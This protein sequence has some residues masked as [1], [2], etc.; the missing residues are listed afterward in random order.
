[1]NKV[2]NIC[3]KEFV[4][5]QKSRI[6]C[7]S[8]SC[9]KIYQSTYMKKYNLETKKEQKQRN[10]NYYLQNKE[11]IKEQ[12]KEYYLKN[13]NKIKK[14]KKEYK[15]QYSLKNKEKI[16]EDSKVYNLKNKIKIRENSR[17]HYLK[18]VEKNTCFCGNKKLKDSKSCVMCCRY[19]LEQRLT[20]EECKQALRKNWIL[21]KDRRCIVDFKHRRLYVH[22]LMWIVHNG[23]HIPNGMTV[24]HIYPIS[25]FPEDTDSK[26]MHD[27]TNLQLLSHSDNS[28]KNDNQN[29]SKVL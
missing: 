17:K 19:G 21:R 15:K 16:K 4:Q 23:C 29:W 11:Q 7:Y 3:F 6:K 5:K 22:R 20:V 10:R 25:R 1:M 24:D 2:C 28:K 14:Y 27:I 9:I 8:Y 12:V 26:I 13:I 18:T